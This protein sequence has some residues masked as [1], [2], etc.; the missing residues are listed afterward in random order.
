[1]TNR[2][3]QS[4]KHKIETLKEDRVETDMEDDKLRTDMEDSK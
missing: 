3:K 1:M 4:G 2:D